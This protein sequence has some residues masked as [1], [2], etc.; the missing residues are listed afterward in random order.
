MPPRRRTHLTT[1]IDFFTRLVSR[2]K[3]TRYTQAGIS[4]LLKRLS[5]LQGA[6]V[7]SEPSEPRTLHPWETPD[8]DL[9]PLLSPEESEDE[10]EGEHYCLGVEDIEEDEFSTDDAVMLEGLRGLAPDWFVTRNAWG[11]RAPR[12][13][14]SLDTS[15]GNTVHYEGPQMGAYSHDTC[16]AKVR[17]I[18]KYHMDTNGWADIAYSTIT[19]RHGYVYEGRGYRVRTAANGTNTGNARSHAHCVMIGVGDDFPEEARDAMRKIVTDYEARGSGTRRWVHKDWRATACP[20]DPATNWT[21]AG[22]P[23]EIPDVYIPPPDMPVELSLNQRVRQNP[24]L[25]RGTDKRHY[26]AIAQA[27]MIAHD[28]W[29]EGGK[30]DGIFG[31]GTEGA[32]RNWLTRIPLPDDPVV[33]ADVWS[34]W[35]GDPPLIKSGSTGHYA[36]QVQALM[37]AHGAWA[38]GGKCDGI[39]GPRSTEALRNWQAKTTLA[40]DGICGPATWAWLLGV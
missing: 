26:V 23:D 3:L 12:S 5:E 21:R 10:P 31:P 30:V 20:G 25:R 14:T 24:E 15:E 38:E 4:W 19:C 1:A 29:A 13:R 16:A 2:L 40:A 11:A 33:T 28:A 35:C 39:F 36:R 27:L 17:G 8:D 18:Q 32:L 9:P 7:P 34:W 22:M 37:I 6:V